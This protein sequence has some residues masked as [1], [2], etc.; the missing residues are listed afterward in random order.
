MGKKTEKFLFNQHIFD[1]PDLEEEE[2]EEPPPPTFS[3]EELETV[4]KT[5]QDRAFEQ[6]RQAGIDEKKASIEA[7]VAQVLQKIAQDTAVLFAA[8]DAREKLFEQESVKLASAIFEK[9]FPEQKELHGFDELKKSLSTILKKQEGHSE[10]RIEVHPSAVEGVQNHINTLNLQGGAQQRFNIIGNESLSEL[11]VNIY[12]KDGGAI[13]DI[14][15]IAEEIRTILHETLASDAL[16]SHDSNS[17][18]SADHFASEEPPQTAS[19]PLEE[20]T[21]TEH[22]YQEDESFDDTSMSDNEMEK[23][24]E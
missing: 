5:T 13:R 18:A 21:G 1:E 15:T 3:E 9:I 2:F 11:A 6:G 19:S 23:P 14:D 16:N 10:I 17:G 4:R 22:A 8:E 12:W 7:Q 20:P 24:D